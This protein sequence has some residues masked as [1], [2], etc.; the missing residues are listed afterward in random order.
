MSDIIVVGAGLGG[1]SAAIRLAV[2]GHQVRV[3]E[4]SN[5]AGGKAGSVTLE[6]VSVD[7]GP[8]V[9]TMPDVLRDLLHSGGWT[10]EDQLELLEPEPA[11]RYLYPNGACLDIY[12][13]LEQSIESVLS[14]IYGSLFGCINLGL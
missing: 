4:A 9:L 14:I 7:T 8:S 10:L 11:F 2:K 5:S 12:P 13:N 6:G 3:F 1:L